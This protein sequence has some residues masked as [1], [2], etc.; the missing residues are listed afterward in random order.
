M[1]MS[2]W[3]I[4]RSIERVDPDYERMAA[5]MLDLLLQLENDG[6]LDDLLAALP[7]LPTVEGEQTE[8]A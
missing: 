2:R 8:A 6:H 3:S 7:P 4:S 1:S 5:A